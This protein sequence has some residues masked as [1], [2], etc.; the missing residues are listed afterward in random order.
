M[1]LNMDAIGLCKEYY[2]SKKRVRKES[3]REGREE[4][5]EGE[6]GE[7]EREMRERMRERMRKREEGRERKGRATNTLTH[8]FKFCQL[9]STIGSTL[10]T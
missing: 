7:G 2:N 5:G 9:L 8:F 10:H 4:R 1:I 6:R 3:R